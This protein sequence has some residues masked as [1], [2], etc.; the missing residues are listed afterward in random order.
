VTSATAATIHGSEELAPVFA[1]T[2]F[3]AP[4]F[5]IEDAG[6]PHS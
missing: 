1:T 3:D 5:W 6:V 4:T 2:D